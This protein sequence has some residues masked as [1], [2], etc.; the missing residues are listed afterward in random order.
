MEIK[1]V[2]N[3]KINNVFD[4]HLDF[5]IINK[6]FPGFPWSYFTNACVCS[7]DA[8]ESGV[9]FKGRPT[10]K[11]LSRAIG[12]EQEWALLRPAC[13]Q[14]QTLV[15]ALLFGKAQE[16]PKTLIYLSKI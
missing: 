13:E 12:L 7:H 4:V 6:L 16:P 10:T 14:Q 2:I 3:I 15:C 8:I 5:Q 9:E 11:R 1:P